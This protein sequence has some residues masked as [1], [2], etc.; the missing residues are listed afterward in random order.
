M[1]HA[2]GCGIPL[3]CNLSVVQHLSLIANQRK[4]LHSSRPSFCRRRGAS[5]RSSSA[6]GTPSIR[7]RRRGPRTSPPRHSTVAVVLSHRRGP[8]PRPATPPP[9]SATVAG[10]LFSRRRIRGSSRP[11]AGHHPCGS[12][13]VSTPL[14]HV[15]AP[16]PDILRPARSAPSHRIREPSPGSAPLLQVV[17]AA[18]RVFFSVPSC[19][20]PSLSAPSHVVGHSICPA[21]DQWDLPALPVRLKICVVDYAGSPCEPAVQLTV[22]SACGCGVYLQS[23]QRSS[24]RLSVSAKIG[25]ISLLSPVCYQNLL[26]FVEFNIYYSHSK[27]C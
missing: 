25:G 6:A 5:G 27:A 12:S 21:S 11:A 3:F 2:S 8:T 26:R 20:G 17:A 7:S 23:S 14:L 13:P 9:T 22:L 1:G 18:R 16:P 19:R 10:R 24:P 15:E 4:N